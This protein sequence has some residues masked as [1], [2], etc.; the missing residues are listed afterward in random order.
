MDLDQDGDIDPVVCSIIDNSIS[1]YRNPGGGAF[2]P[3]EII[4]TGATNVRQVAFGDFD[5]DT[6]IDIVAALFGSNQLV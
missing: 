4:A 3:Q 6:D 1:W 2:N 5:G